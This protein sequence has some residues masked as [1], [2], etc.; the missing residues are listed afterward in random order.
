MKMKYVKDFKMFED[1]EVT[2]TIIQQL[3]G[4]NRLKVMIGAY[5]FVGSSKEDFLTFRFKAK[6]KNGANYIKIKL[7]SMDLYDIE[8][9]K[10][11]ADKY[12]IIKKEEGL[13]ADMLKRIIE[14][15]TKLRLSL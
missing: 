2:K 4:T 10:I 11:Y 12:T 7:T 8:F 1:M 5:N 13:Y 14:D 9:G 3:G 6:A 15:E